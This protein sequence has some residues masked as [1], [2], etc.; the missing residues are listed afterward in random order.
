MTVAGISFTSASAELAAMMVEHEA[1]QAENDH[2]QMEAYQQKIARE[3]EKEY[4]AA[5]AAA[6]AG[7]RAALLGGA[8]GILQSGGTVAG[9]TQGFSARTQDEQTLATRI[10]SLGSPFQAMNES[11]QAYGGGIEKERQ[12]ARAQQCNRT[13]QQMQ[14]EANQ[15]AQQARRSEQRSDAALDHASKFVESDNARANAVLSNF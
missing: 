9:A 5:M 3:A 11:V 2:E 14:S 12:Q 4:R 8:M 1:N 6:D 7:A 13:I 10:A 15:L